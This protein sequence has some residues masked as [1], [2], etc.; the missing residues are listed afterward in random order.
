MDLGIRGLTDAVEIGRGGFAVVYRASQPAFDRTVAV[1]VL[2]NLH[3]DEAT[4]ISFERECTAIGKVSER[5]NILTVHDEGRTT[6]GVPYLIM[7]Y[8]PQ[9][10]LADLIKRAGPV[11]WP[12]AV[13]IGV[14]L[15]RALQVAHHAG[16]LHRD[17]KPANVL[18]SDDEGPQLADFGIARLAGAAQSTTGS[19][20]FTPAYAAP[21]VLDGGTA[22]AAMDVYSLACTLFT[23]MAGRPAF[24]EGPGDNVAAI[25]RRVSSAPPPDLLRPNGVPEPVCHVIEQAMGKNPGARPA[26]AA[27][28]AIQLEAARLKANENRT[29]DAPGDTAPHFQKDPKARR[30]FSRRVQLMSLPLLLVLAV[31]V[32]VLATHSPSGSSGTRPPTTLASPANSVALAPP[33]AAAGAPSTTVSKAPIAPPGVGLGTQLRAISS[34]PC[35]SAHFDAGSSWEVSAVQVG[36]KTYQSAYSCN[37]FTSGTGSLDFVLDKSYRLLNVTIGFADDSASL[38]QVVKFEVIGNGSKY[39]TPPQ[40]LHFGETADLVVDVSGIS[41]L[42][43][44]AS[45]QSPATIASSSS[46]PVWADPTLL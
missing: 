15:A 6:A 9:G 44:Q 5:A 45:E 17:I 10:S 39:L 32:G 24:V 43:L 34:V 3:V 4:L 33:N 1:K 13:D 25:M 26:S 12:D 41:Q 36:R 46:H 7:A 20:A 38:Q 2:S 22:T 14:K 27:A 28:F 16:I 30:L 29:P 37:M 40:T 8:M 18:M 31:I 35:R 19:V 11:R 21:E 23:A 42:K